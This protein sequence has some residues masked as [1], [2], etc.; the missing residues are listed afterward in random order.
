MRKKSSGP[1]KLGAGLPCR[2]FQGGQEGR[3]MCGAYGRPQ[4]SQS[5]RRAP[6]FITKTNTTSE[7]SSPSESGSPD[8]RHVHN[9]QF[10]PSQADSSGG[11]G[12]CA[13]RVASYP[14]RM[15]ASGP[16]GPPRAAASQGRLCVHPRPVGSPT[17][18]PPL[19]LRPQRQGNRPPRKHRTRSTEAAAAGRARRAPRCLPGTQTPALP[20]LA[21]RRPPQKGQP[22]NLRRHSP[23]PPP[24]GLES[25]PRFPE[26]AEKVRP[27]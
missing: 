2:R 18:N 16:A 10:Q 6:A 7:A 20:S 11:K 14:G 1:S 22:S 23:G 5:A 21:P 26:A 25:T 17:L 24:P 4:A 12:G 8:P 9:R 19:P 13:C 15:L 27:R 3:L